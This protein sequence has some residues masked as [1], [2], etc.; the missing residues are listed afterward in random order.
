[1]NCS[2]AWP[3]RLLLLGVSSIGDRVHASCN[4][5]HIDYNSNNIGSDYPGCILNRRA[6]SVKESLLFLKA[7]VQLI[8]SK[9]CLTIF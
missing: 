3:T 1:M 6:N 5:S 4:V 2:L 8:P 9:V 7:N